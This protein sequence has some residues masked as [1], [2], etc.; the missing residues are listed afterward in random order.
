MWHTLIIVLTDLQNYKKNR[1]KER[2]VFF[3]LY[4]LTYLHERKG[5]NIMCVHI[6][7]G[8]IN[9]KTLIDT[10]FINNWKNPFI[11]NYAKQNREK[12]WH[13]AFLFYIITILSND[14]YMWIANEADGGG[15][16]NQSGWMRVREHVYV[17]EDGSLI[18]FDTCIR[19]RN[20]QNICS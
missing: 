1:E 2:K 7:F 6:C 5:V 9:K 18:K 19:K 10:Q 16:T 17:W 3:L 4:L 20:C 13:V 14:S 8:S 15:M 11:F 12:K